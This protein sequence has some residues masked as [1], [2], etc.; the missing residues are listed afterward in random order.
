MANLNKLFSDFNKEITLKSK[1]KENL[2]RGRN[3]L[4]DKIRDKFSEKD[5]SKPKF[6]GQG[7]YM[8]KT[9][10]NPIDS[11]YDL[12]DG[13]YIQGYSEK[14]I[15]EWPKASTIHTWIKD[16]VDGHTSKSPVDKNTCVRVIYV[17]DYHIDLPA[18][19]MKDDK[20][21]LAHKRD[22]WIV[23]DPKAFTD[24][25]RGKV[26]NDGEQLRSLV[27]YLKAWKDYKK[28]DLKGIS[29][30]ILVGENFYDYENRD[31]LA[32]LGTLTNIIESL[33]DKFECVKPV[34]PNE[35][36]FEGYSETKQAEIIKA[37]T[38][39]RDSIQKAVDK[40]DEKEASDIMINY[41][42]S[43][44]PQG[45]SSTAED[46]SEYVQAEAPAVLKNDG[47]SA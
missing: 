15:K 9:V 21:Y 42:G 38:D 34:A 25:F 3:A 37:I 17:N 43:R 16:A 47:R 44:F 32:L 31:D 7:S 41:F 27:K 18:Y 40:E 30:T 36:L 46:K 19:I 29:I 45:E 23:S 12:D 1:K 11:E 13:V 28:V 33:E 14:E 39:L 24:W 5:R 10:V 2:K 6:C 26:K 22:G 20:A 8:M 35:N 4:R